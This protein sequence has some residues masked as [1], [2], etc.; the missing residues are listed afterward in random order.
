MA[1]AYYPGEGSV[2][3][4]KGVIKGDEAVRTFVLNP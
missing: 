2:R 3:R 1:G 4:G